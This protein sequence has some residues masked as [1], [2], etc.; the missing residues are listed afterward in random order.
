MKRLILLF[1]IICAGQLYGMGSKTGP[2]IK[3][4]DIRKELLPE[5]RQEL[6][7]KALAVSNTPAEAINTIKN[8][9]FVHGIQFDELN[10]DMLI[11]ALTKK[12]PD[13]TKAELILAIE[14]PE[15][16][17]KVVAILK[18]SKNL[19]DAIRIVKQ[20]NLLQDNLKNFTVL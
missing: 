4:F 15:V 2:K 19:S 10:K 20:E 14:K 11:H 6:I 3:E 8:L 9:S 7:S 1:T 12:F 17:Q 18:E 13:K 16:Y 5:L